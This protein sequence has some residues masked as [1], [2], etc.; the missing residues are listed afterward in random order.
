MS[1][2]R[3]DPFDVEN[4]LLIFFFSKSVTKKRK[5][6]FL[7]SVENRS[8]A[9]FFGQRYANIIASVRRRIANAAVA[10]A[11]LALIAPPRVRAEVT[12]FWDM[13]P[14]VSHLKTLVQLVCGD[15]EGGETTANNFN[16]DGLGISQLRS[17]YYLLTGDVDRAVDVQ[18]RFAENFEVVLD[19]TP[20][21]GHVKGAA[22]LIAGDTEHGWSAVKQ[23]TST[24]GSVAGAMLAG[25][26][27]SV[28]GH[29]AT[30]GL[31]SLADWAINR[32]GARPHGVID[33]AMTFRDRKPGE[34]VDVLAGLAMNGIGGSVKPLARQ[35]SSATTAAAP[36]AVTNSTAEKK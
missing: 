14:L 9:S 15:P 26:V 20:V 22:H 13:V 16:N 27:G 30:D 12:P 32:D 34:A 18:K 33:Y 31:I 23:A 17:L 25:P 28:L 6:S 19:S 4:L 36:T 11:L 8:R 3:A 21:L 35:P 24:T 29:V 7:K 1:R 5:K 10:F 2:S